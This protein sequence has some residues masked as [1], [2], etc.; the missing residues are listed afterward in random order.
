MTKK[1][2]MKKQ[3]GIENFGKKTQREIPY[4][5][6]DSF[7]DPNDINWAFVDAYEKTVRKFMLEHGEQFCEFVKVKTGC[8]IYWNENGKI[9]GSD[10]VRS[11]ISQDDFERLM[12]EFVYKNVLK[13]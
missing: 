11:K 8:E 13:M 12:A 6:K 7:N 2:K 5:L 1:Q 4:W 3:A 10:D 9:F